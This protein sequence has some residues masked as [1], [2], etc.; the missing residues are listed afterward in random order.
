M[1]N[2]EQYILSKKNHHVVGVQYGD[3]G[4]GSITSK[5]INLFNLFNNNTNAY[6]NNIRYGGGMQVGHTTF[7]G[8]TYIENHGVPSGYHI[9]TKLRY[10]ETKKINFFYTENCVINIDILYN[11]LLFYQN[12]HKTY[13]IINLFPYSPVTT[14]LDV[15]ENRIQ[16]IITN[17][18]STGMGFGKTVERFETT[19]LKFTLS[20][21]FT[22]LHSKDLIID[23]L[24]Q[25]AN[26]YKILIDEEFYSLANDF[27]DKL[28]Y[29]DDVLDINSN[30]EYIINGLNSINIF[31][32]HQ[33]ALLDKDSSDFP[34]VTR[35]KTTCILP[36]SY[37]NNKLSNINLSN[38]PIDTRNKLYNSLSGKGFNIV[39]SSTGSFITHMVTRIYSTRHGNGYFKIDP[40][41]LKNN[42]NESNKFNPYQ[43]E[44]KT[45]KL[46]FND[47]ERGISYVIRD[48]CYNVIS[49]ETVINDY[50]NIF[51]NNLILHVTCCD[52]VDLDY[53]YDTITK[54][55]NM[56]IIKDNNIRIKT[57]ETNDFHI[58]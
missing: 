7:D 9:L 28:L 45:S 13:K 25:I 24:K 36:I 17:H 53:Y 50:V 44:F 20:D 23:Q 10:P 16:N 56:K 29:I 11:D 6:I 42:K 21:F 8:T 22:N 39:L 35:S 57:H 33:G 38:T 34:H 15:H 46:N 30:P 3:E 26:H 1:T 58:F 47:L 41:V 5:L 18:G 32:G 2:L 43:L 27:Y 52:Q 55:E 4:K 40:I 49:S 14:F 48:L 37:F 54:I 31:E 19:T 12:K 51:K